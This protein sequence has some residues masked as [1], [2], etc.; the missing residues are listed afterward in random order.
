MNFD[1][2]KWENAWPSC[3]HHI[4][5]R[6]ALQCIHAEFWSGSL[7]FTSMIF[8]SSKKKSAPKPG[9]L[10]KV[11]YQ[12]FNIFIFLSSKLIEIGVLLAFGLSQYSREIQLTSYQSNMTSVLLWTECAV[13]HLL[14]VSSPWSSTAC[15]YWGWVH[16]GLVPL[17]S[18][19]DLWVGGGTLGLLCCF[20]IQCFAFEN[21][22]VLAA[23]KMPEPRGV[24]Q[25]GFCTTFLRARKLSSGLYLQFLL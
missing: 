13:K 10:A 7:G 15:L 2:W 4:R 14:W 11:P 18:L 25:K 17:C 16:S 8:N 5:W 21:Q 24:P 12:A 9:F 3:T 6:M 19:R 1:C 20:V 22:L 23:V